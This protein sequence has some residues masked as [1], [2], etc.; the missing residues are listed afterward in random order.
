VRGEETHSCGDGKCELIRLPSGGAYC[1]ISGLLMPAS[2]PCAPSALQPIEQLSEPEEEVV[3][4]L[5][6]DLEKRKAIANKVYTQLLG[7]RVVNDYREVQGA[8]LQRAKNMGIDIRQQGKA[9]VA[10]AQATCI[11]W[12]ELAVVTALLLAQAQDGL[13]GTDGHFIVPPS[14]KLSRIL[15]HARKFR[16]L[17]IPAGLINQG[18][19][20]IMRAKPSLVRGP[21]PV[22]TQPFHFRTRTER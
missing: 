12:T 8:A 7:T 11:T 22:L 14:E 10:E 6:E 21:P 13:R 2:E 16:L 18:T 19:R 17:G 5:F 3:C 9:I 20:I 1:A 15:P 4:D